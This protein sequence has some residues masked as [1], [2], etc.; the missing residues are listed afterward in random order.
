[1]PVYE[2]YLAYL[3]QDQDAGHLFVG[4]CAYPPGQRVTRQPASYPLQ[5]EDP[6]V[7]GVQDASSLLLPCL[8]ACH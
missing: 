4:Q 8:I 2:R 7:K 5:V 3:A 6:G 1:M